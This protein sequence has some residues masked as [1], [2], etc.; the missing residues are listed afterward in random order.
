MILTSL[1]KICQNTSLSLIFVIAF[2]LIFGDQLPP[3]IT[4]FFYSLSLSIKEILIMLLPFIIFTYLAS[5]ILSLKQGA[6]IFIIVLLGMVLVSNF[7]SI[8][9]G[10]LAYMADLIAVTSKGNAIGN[11]AVLEPLWDLCLPKII[12]ND[13]ALFLGLA[14]G[15][16]FTYWRVAHIE[17]GIVVLKKYVDFFMNQLFIPILP[18]FILGFVLKLKYDGILGEILQEYTPVLGIIV[19][20]QIFYLTILYVVAAQFN[21]SKAVNYFKNVLP[22]ALAGFTTMSSAAAMPLSIQSAENNTGDPEVARAIIPATLNIH[23]IGDSVT[24]SI[25]VMVL[26]RTFGF[27]CLTFYDYLVFTGYFMI[28]KFAVAA[29]PGG[30]IFVMVPVLEAQLGFTPEMSALI[31]ALYILFDPI[32]TAANVSGNGAFAVLF[33]RVMKRRQPVI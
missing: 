32:T 28:S 29:V 6:M 17:K 2:A 8:L 19:A 33:S 30:T 4:A 7:L 16:L 13:H 9:T 22:A 15:I 23:M 31:T 26:M 14:V 12:G 18:V 1:K 21:F 24:I 10:Y 5:C 27:E 20:L 25:M 11:M 3:Q